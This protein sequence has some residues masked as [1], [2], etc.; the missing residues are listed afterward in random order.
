MAWS[1]R[2]V[3]LAICAAALAVAA[4]LALAHARVL[5]QRRAPNLRLSDVSSRGER[6]ARGLLAQPDADTAYE[7]EDL[8]DEDAP[9]QRSIAVAR[10]ALGTAAA[11]LSA[12]Q[13]W[14]DAAPSG[15]AASKVLHPLLEAAGRALEAALTAT[16]SREGQHE[17]TVLPHQAPAGAEDDEDSAAGGAWAAAVQRRV[18][19]ALRPLC[20]SGP[21]AGGASFNVAEWVSLPPCASGLHEGR[22]TGALH[23]QRR[24]LAQQQPPQGKPGPGPLPGRD[25]GPGGT[26]PPVPQPRAVNSVNIPGERSS[27]P[28]ARL[29]S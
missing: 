27:E 2:R 21:E 9:E 24:R 7:E 15:R 25:G 12:A 19:R 6:R 1:S 16:A 13:E 14:I 18:Q 26:L 22:G 10:A 5:L 23:A 4:L 3:R 11:T 20:L 29:P 28:S 17:V 8:S